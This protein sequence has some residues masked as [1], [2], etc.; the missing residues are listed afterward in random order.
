VFGLGT[1]E[2]VAIA[3]LAVALLMGVLFFNPTASTG[4]N[5]T[6]G[7]ISL[8]Q[9]V[10]ST[11]APTATATPVP[12]HTVAKPTSQWYLVYYE[13]GVN[14]SNIKSGEG[15]VDGLNFDI[16]DRP[17]PDFK[18]DAWSMEVSNSVTVA[19]G[20]NRFQL[21]VDGEVTVKI[22][23]EVVA[24]APNGDSPVT[25]PVEFE[26]KAGTVAL[27]VTVRDTGGPVRLRWV[28]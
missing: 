5:K 17:F 19:D 13:N 1:R 9:I 22:G 27:V 14:G 2:F 20:I 4:T 26:H 12:I 10:T 8:G 6:P 3:V 28:D 15:F 16:S 24:Q 7:T 25:L 23:D 21:E 18:P 11:P